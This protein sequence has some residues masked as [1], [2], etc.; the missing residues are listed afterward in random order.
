MHLSKCENAIYIFICNSDYNNKKRSAA[1]A[2]K[3]TQKMEQ[4]GYL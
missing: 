2:I 3:N 4:G 1:K